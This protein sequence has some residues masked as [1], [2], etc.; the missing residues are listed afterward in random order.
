[1]PVLSARYDGL[2][3]TDAK[4]RQEARDLVSEAR[5]HAEVSEKHSSL[6]SYTRRLVAKDARTFREHE[7]DLAECTMCKTFVVGSFQTLETSW[8]H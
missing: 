1:M 8:T 3:L 4:W 2:Q 5:L 7:K 6:D